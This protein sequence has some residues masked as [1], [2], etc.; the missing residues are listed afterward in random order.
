MSARTASRRSLIAPVSRTPGLNYGWPITEGLHCFRPQTGCDAADLTLPVLEVQHGDA[1]TCSITG[2]SRL[3]RNRDTG[4][5]RAL[6]VLRLLR[7]ATC[8]AFPLDGFD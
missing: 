8:L 2:G 6:P 1:G 5:V 4:A 7:G 3:P